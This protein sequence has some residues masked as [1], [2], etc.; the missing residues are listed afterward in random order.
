MND[1]LVK[2]K[3][4]SFLAMI[5]M[6]YKNF[7]M[8]FQQQRY[9]FTSERELLLLAFTG[10]LILFM[11]NLPVQIIRSSVVEEIDLHIYIGLIAFVS[12]FFI[13]LF[14]YIVSTILFF[15]FK[16]FKGSASFY[17]LRL[18]LFWSLNV[19]GPLL[20]LNGLLKG[21]FFNFE[22]IGLMSLILNSFAA[23]IISSILATAQNYKSAL[24]TF[25]V[26]VAFIITPQFV[27]Q[28]LS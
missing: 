5:F 25:F 18:A 26:A 24:P 11:A 28:I 6:A 15:I 27:P 1:S 12:F 13:P 7:S 22:W 14:L 16:V 20:I 8:S 17:E 21:F 2:A 3:R 23:W 4:K 10:T 19:A 9:S